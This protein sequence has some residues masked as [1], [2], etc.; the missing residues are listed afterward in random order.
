[1]T[2][3]P[4]RLRPGD[5]DVLV[6]RALGLGDALTGVAPLRGVRRAWPD[7]RLVLAAPAGVGGWLARLGVVDAVLPTDGLQP[8][9]L[10]ETEWWP[11]GHLAVNLHGRGP[12]SHRLLQATRPDRMVAF[13]CPE[14]GHEGPPWEPDEH[15]VARWCR[16]VRHAGGDCGAED[17]RLP[18][19]GDRGPAVVLHPGAASAA[20]R[21]P[22][23]RWTDLA[24]RLV[25]SGRPVVLTGSAAEE[26]LCRAVVEQVPGPRSLAGRLD[27]AELAD[28]VGTARLLVCGDTGV[29]HLATALATPSV[30]LFGPTPPQWW[31]PAIDQDRHSVLW[32]GEGPGDPHADRV[33][34]ALTAIGPDE[35]WAAVTAQLGQ[36]PLRRS[37]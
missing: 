30:L 4:G 8:A 24:R 9:W 14:A 22:V 1:M 26:P 12:Q 33:D 2:G 17:L 32:H 11:G 6:L 31:G 10:E 15:E 19:T 21:W 28:L 25:R 5:G 13:G 29:A 34:P 23:D 20:R 3:E 18:T 36:Q 27:L 16:L 35:V 7:H 37:G